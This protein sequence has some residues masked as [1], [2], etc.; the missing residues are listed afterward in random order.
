MKKIVFLLYVLVLIS[1][2]N[3]DSSSDEITQEQ[4]VQKKQEI[5]NYI[6]SFECTG[7][8]NY[9]AFGSK[10]CGGPREY[11]VFPST[12][13]FFVINDL[14]T[15]YNEMDNLFNIQTGAVSD[16]MLVTPPTNLDC[17]NGDCVILN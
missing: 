6:N 1:C 15:E 10:P 2:T 4:L 11:L 12:V 17:V 14:V 9:I 13:D 7:S 16:C 8:C 3:N 5:L